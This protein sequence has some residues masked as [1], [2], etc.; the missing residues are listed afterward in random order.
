M[1]GGKRFLGVII[2]RGGS[3]GVPRKNVRWVAGKPLMAW[4]IQAGQESRLLDRLIISSEDEEILRVARQYGCDV[5]FVRPRELAEDHV[6]GVEPVIHAM[7]QLP[8]YDFV[9]L[10]QATSPLR[11]GED[12]D[13]AIQ[14]CVDRGA[15]VC[16][17][18]SESP[19]SP[20]WMYTVDDESRMTPIIPVGDVPRRRQL[21]HTTYVLNG[22]VYVCSC[23]FLQRERRFLTDKTVGYLM[24][25]DRAIDV[26]S[27]TDLLL[28]DLI[29]SRRGTKRAAA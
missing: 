22:A 9:V 4:T 16:T 24:P 8:G 6:S 19:K 11:T 12:I 26:D 23:D 10:L 3:K 28:A 13:G 15:D 1:Y 29:L 7:E 2:A 20:V 5:P 21:L 18:L 14:L 25:A 17:T 27:E